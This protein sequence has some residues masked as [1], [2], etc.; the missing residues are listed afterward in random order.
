VRLVVSYVRMHPRPFAIAVAGAF[1]Y[2]IGSV[3]VTIAL[4]R[5]TDR[6]LRPAFT[7]EGVDASAVWLGIGAVMALTALR[8]LGIGIRRYYS[9]VM[10][11]AVAAT[12]RERVSDR[13]R[14]LSL[15]YHRTRPTGELLAHM[16]ADVEAAIEVLYPI[17]FAIGVIFLVL[18][19]LVSLVATDPFLTLIGLLTVPALGLMNRSFALQ[20]HGPA[21]R[22]QERIGDVSAV[23]HESIDGALVVK[24]LGRERAEVG[25]FRE[26][27]ERLRTERVAAGYIRAWFEEA[28]EALPSL[29]VILMLAIGAWRVPTGDITLGT[30]VQVVTLFGLLESRAVDSSG[31][32]RQSTAWRPKGWNR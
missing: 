10:G 12:L 26:K 6:V 19:A 8:A 16:E 13:Y 17:P 18:F 3:A 1:M 4:G 21:L 29:A 25:R 31:L 2:A 11:S 32:G 24:T 23:A 28:L 14:D 27:A 22:V 7:P 20:M 9:G 30:L 15:S 5:V